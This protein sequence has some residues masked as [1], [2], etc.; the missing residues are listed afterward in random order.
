MNITGKK[1]IF[2]QKKMIGKIWEKHLTTALNVLYA[3]KVK[4]S[5]AYISKHNLN[6]EKQDNLLMTLN[7]EG[8]DYLAAKKISALLRGITSK[9]HSNFYC[10]NSLHSFA[11]ENKHESHKNVCENRNFVTF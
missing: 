10:L 8:W 1:Y 9:H 7:G 3:K 11:T 2:H 4:I 6:R 5:P